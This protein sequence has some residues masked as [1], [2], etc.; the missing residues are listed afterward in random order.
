MELTHAQQSADY[1]CTKILTAYLNNIKAHFGDRLRQVLNLICQKDKKSKEVQDKMKAARYDKEAIKGVIRNSVTIPCANAK[2]S[3]A[4]KQLPEGSFLDED[5]KS[6]VASILATYPE[7]YTFLNSSIYYDVKANPLNHMKAFYR[8][9][10]ILQSLTLDT[11]KNTC[12]SFI[13]FPLRTSFIPAYITVDTLIMNYHILGFKSFKEEK[14]VIWDKVLNMKYKAL[15]K[16]GADKSLCFQGMILTDG[17]TATVLKQNFESGRR[18]KVN[19]AITPEQSSSSTKGRKGKRSE[20]V[21]DEDGFKYIEDLT[22]NQLKETEDNC[23]LIDPGRRDIL[24]C[25]KETSKVDNR[26]LFRFTKNQISTVK[27]FKKQTEIRV[28]LLSRA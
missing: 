20:P 13:V 7:S 11:E 23:V 6:L 27:I 21:D 24:Y 25:M 26:Q 12:K 22:K 3:V 2:T 9:D 10:Q 5:Q 28:Y 18:Q 16:Q 17:V 19:L 1:E 4:R 8:L 14:S 15:K